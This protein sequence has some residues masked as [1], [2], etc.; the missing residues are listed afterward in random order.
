MI[1]RR[2]MVAVTRAAR[3]PRDQRRQHG[4]RADS[5]ELQVIAVLEAA[6]IGNIEQRKDYADT[7]LGLFAELASVLIM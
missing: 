1:C 6:H 3:K 4:Y 7:V 2:A 5:V